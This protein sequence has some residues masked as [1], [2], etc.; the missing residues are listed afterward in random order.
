MIVIQISA[1]YPSFV[2]RI[3]IAR[4]ISIVGIFYYMPSKQGLK[5]SIKA[6][7]VAI[8]FYVTIKTSLINPQKELFLNSI[9]YRLSN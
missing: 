4:G 1:R 3:K 5:H 7:V 6:E 2:S 8:L 9:D